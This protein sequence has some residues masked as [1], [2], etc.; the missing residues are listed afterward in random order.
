MSSILAYLGQR[1][2][3]IFQTKSDKLESICV[4]FS[5]ACVLT[6]FLQ[7]VGKQTDG[8]GFLLSPIHR[9]GDFCGHDRIDCFSSKHDK[10]VIIIHQNEEIISNLKIIETL[11][12]TLKLKMMKENLYCLRRRG[13]TLFQ[14]SSRKNCAREWVLEVLVICWILQEDAGAL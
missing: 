12:I 13:T 4:N 6:I 11:K 10:Y 1:N 7:H 2:F 3:Q 8:E 5:I 14:A 9:R